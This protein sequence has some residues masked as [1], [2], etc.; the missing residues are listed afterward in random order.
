MTLWD[1]YRDGVTQSFINKFLQCKYQ[2]YLEFVEGLTPIRVGDKLRLG[3]KGHKILQE[4][5][6]KGRPLT[7]IEI[8]ELLMEEIIYD[9]TL[10]EITEDQVLDEVVF[11]ICKLYFLLRQFE[12]FS[13]EYEWLHVEKSFK[14]PYENTFLCGMWDGVRKSV[15]GELV[16][17]DH[18]FKSNPD[19]EKIQETLSLD[20]QINTYC[21]AAKKYF[22]RIPNKIVYNV[23]RI[24]GQ[25]FTQKDT[26]QTYCEKIIKDVKE[27]PSHYFIPIRHTPT[28]EELWDWEQRQLRPILR[29]IE[30]WQHLNFTPRYINP[31]ALLINHQRCMLYNYIVSGGSMAGL[32][33]KTKCFEE[34]E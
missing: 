26:N 30:D 23:I 3:S 12:D 2:C 7:D 15:H 11:T 6:L 34:L 24:P 18:K 21:L 1:Y 28:M 10:E 8:R 5:Y 31:N 13:P 4:G 22:G 33:H 32:T 29:E 14:L 16:I 9:R 25:R 19:E 20:T 27:R 17:W